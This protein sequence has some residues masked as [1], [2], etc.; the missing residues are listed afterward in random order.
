[1]WSPWSAAAE[2]RISPV[3]FW[4]QG[5][6]RIE[7]RARRI[8]EAGTIDATPVIL[9]VPIGS[10]PT[11]IDNPALDFH[12]QAGEGGCDCSTGSPAGGPPPP[13]AL[14][15]PPLP[16]PPIPIRPAPPPE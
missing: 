7:V 12:G 3:S 16:P 15:P 8:G 6:H 14:R 2:H 4:V 9:D 13:A 1:M 11:P 5:T 10:I